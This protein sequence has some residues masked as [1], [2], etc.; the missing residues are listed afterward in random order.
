MNQLLSQFRAFLSSE[1]SILVTTQSRWLFIFTC[2]FISTLFLNI[3]DP[4]DIF[5]YYINSQIGTLI[6]IG[7]A[8]I[9]GSGTLI[10][11]QFGIRNWWG[12][13]NFRVYSLV[14]WAIFEL[15]IV[16][17]LI[18]IFYG[19]RGQPFISEFFLTYQRTFL[20]AIIPYFSSLLLLYIKDLIKRT[21]TVKKQTAL[22]SLSDDKGKV[23]LSTKSENLLFFKSEDNYVQIHYLQNNIEHKSLIRNTLKAILSQLPTDNFV[24]IHRSYVINTSHIAQIEKTKGKTLVYLDHVSH[25]T[26][27]VSSTYEKNLF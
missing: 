21:K 25:S 27:T 20:L 23:I 24:Q 22:I 9:I 17:I 16:S 4:L 2:A 19:E 12:P 6:T 11:T 18:F 10:I 3:Y 8:G 13:K 15:S 1:T 5:D 14:G 26:F 7:Y